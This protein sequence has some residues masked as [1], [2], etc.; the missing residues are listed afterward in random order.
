[1]NI[2]ELVQPSLGAAIVRWAKKVCDREG[3]YPSVKSAK[4]KLRELMDKHDGQALRA[5]RNLTT[6]NPDVR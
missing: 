1:M 3:Y 4:A 6:S 5:V 2:P